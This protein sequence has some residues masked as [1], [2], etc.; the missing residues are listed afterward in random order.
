[1]REELL[2]IVHF[3]DEIWFDSKGKGHVIALMDI[4]YVEAVLRYLHNHGLHRSEMPKALFTRFNQRH[5]MIT[6]LVEDLDA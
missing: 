6:N 5:N 2:E 3:D 4:D 1:M